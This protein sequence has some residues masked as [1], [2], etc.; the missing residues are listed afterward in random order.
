MGFWRRALGIEPSLERNAPAAGFEDRDPHQRTLPSAPTRTTRAL[1]EGRVTLRKMTALLAVVFVAAP[2]VLAAGAACRIV[3]GAAIGAVRIGM[4]VQAALAVTGPA[5]TQQT[6]GGENVYTLR[7]SWSRMVAEY[8]LVT[9]VATGAEACRTSRG[10]GPGS[11]S[12]AV[13]SAYAGASVR[14]ITPLADGE[15]LSYPL[16]GVAFV[17]RRNRVD[18]VEVFRA[19]GSSS[20]TRPLPPAAPVPQG[21][22]TPPATAPPAVAPAASDGWVIRSTSAQVQGEVLIITG[23]IENRGRAASPYAEVKAYTATGHQVARGDAPLTPT[24][25]PAGGIAMFEVRLTIDDVVRRYTVTLRPARSLT[26]TLAESAGELRDM[27]QFAP[28]VARRLRIA[29][30]VAASPPSP[31]DFSVVVTNSSSLPVAA[32]AV[33]VDL[34]VTCRLAQI[35][36]PIGRQISEQRAGS[37]VV[38]QIAPGASARA[39]LA[40]SAGVCP[41]FAT[42]SAVTRAGDVRIGE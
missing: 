39:K 11:A 8:G 7:G 2:T 30:E 26:A 6:S 13:R 34:T 29:V 22:A 5:S 31:E 17:V 24:P 23:T 20:G 9:R 18:S 33:S 40:L 27:Q 4:P 37:V 36:F 35:N 41:Q 21:A 12:G 1:Y 3:E 32:A 10:V 19:E 16:L 14:A 25:V 15:L 42:W 38:Q 28:L